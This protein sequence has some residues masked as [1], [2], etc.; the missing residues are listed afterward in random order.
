MDPRRESGEAVDREVSVSRRLEKI[1]FHECTFADPD[2]G[3]GVCLTPGSGIGK[4]S[5]SGMNI[6][7]HFS[8]CLATVFMVKNT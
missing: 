8:E 4:K 5:R 3:S 1:T 6:P 2:S 7:D